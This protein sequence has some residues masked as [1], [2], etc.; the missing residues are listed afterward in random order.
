ME[1]AEEIV[2]K[3]GADVD[4]L[5]TEMRKAKGSIKDL[6]SQ[7]QKASKTTSMASQTWQKYGS[8]IKGAVVSALIYA[9]TR[10]AQFVGKVDSVSTAFKA[11]AAST[12]MGATALL[13]SI[14]EAARGTVSNL[15]IMESANLA[16]QLMGSE[17]AESLPQMMKIAM[18][19]ARATGKDVSQ[20]FN[21][22]I[23][24]SGRQSVQILDNLG[25]SSA[26][27][28]QKMD[29]YAASL[30]KTREQLTTAEKKA[31]FFYAVMQS[32]QDLIDRTNMG[33]LTL[34]ERIQIMKA[35]AE[36][37]ATAFS[38]KLIPAINEFMTTITTS[39]GTEES[40]AGFVGKVAGSL[41]LV[42]AILLEGLKN[43]GTMFTHWWSLVKMGFLSDI[44]DMAEKGRELA[45]AAGLDAMAAKLKSYRDSIGSALATAN[46]EREASGSLRGR[47]N[48]LEGQLRRL[49]SDPA[50]TGAAANRRIQQL[51]NELDRLR[52]R[53]GG[54][55]H[56]LKEMKQSMFLDYTGA[57]P[58]QV[59]LARE[60]ERYQQ[61]VSSYQLSEEQKTALL[62]AYNRHREQIM[63]QHNAIVQGIAGGLNRSFETAFSA[64]DQANTQ[65]IYN[66][67]WGKGGWNEFKKAAG[68]IMKQL[69]ADIIYAIARA[70]ILQSIL[71]ATGLGG[72]GLLTGAVGK[73]FQK[74]GVPARNGENVRIPVF[75]GG[76]VPSDHMLSFISPNESVINA[77]STA[78]N[79]ALLKWINSN[80]G[81]QAPMG[82]DITVRVPIQLD[83][84]VIGEVADK[85]SYNKARATGSRTR[86][87]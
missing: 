14:K 23:V 78:A 46:R 49:W 16:M 44:W 83:G 58:L 82:G 25:I 27:A 8:I 2:V 54:A 67:M 30:G 22:I 59:A 56:A 37:A 3:I 85:F 34:G 10:F 18:A 40:I 41:I 31:A 80:P 71:S 5:I 1:T 75:A 42:A 76:Y 68:E 64:I 81:Q 21:D 45:A 47:M 20:M 38:E 87:Y 63:L 36:N 55:T 51:Q 9:S 7:Q 72:G 73:L 70:I 4:Q 26:M 60:Q 24:A 39:E 17:V 61:M 15:D 62:Q 32:G 12:S 84:K 74:G 66:M 50:S 33:T 35:Q 65:L 86:R 13:D 57:D 77:R 19:A 29:E 52:R 79:A 6:Q 53:A 48:E 11:L 69:I 28:A 43:F